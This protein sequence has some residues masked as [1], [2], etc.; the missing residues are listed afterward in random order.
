[1]DGGGNDILICNTALFPGCNTLCNTSG[2]ATNPTCQDIVGQALDRAEQLMLDAAAQGVSDVIY[3]YYP[4]IPSNNGGYAYILD[5][6]EPLARASC[7]GAAA[8]TNGDMRCHFVSLIQPFIMAGGDRNPLNF[9]GDG[10]HPSQAGQNIMASEIWA[11]MQSEC[12]GQPASS[13]CCMP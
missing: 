5:Y 8:A 4:H 11:V 9:A 6:A 7:E 10:I 3:F 2:A 12:L 13:G 1:M